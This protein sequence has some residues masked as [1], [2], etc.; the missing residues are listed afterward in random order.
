MIWIFIP[1]RNSGKNHYKDYVTIPVK[2]IKEMLPKFLKEKLNTE[3]ENIK[4]ISDYCIL[5]KTSSEMIAYLSSSPFFDAYGNLLSGFKL[6]REEMLCGKNAILY[7]DPQGVRLVAGDYSATIF[8]G[9]IKNYLDKFDL[10]G[11]KT[12]GILC[13]AGRLFPSIN[14]FAL[15]NETEVLLEFKTNQ[16]MRLANMDEYCLVF[17]K[18]DRLAFSISAFHTKTSRPKITVKS[19]G[20]MHSVKIFGEKVALTI[21]AYSPKSL[22]DTV[23]DSSRNFRNDVYAEYAYLGGKRDRQW[24]CIRPDCS[25]LSPLYHREIKSGKTYFRVL[26]ECKE[27]SVFLGTLHYLWCAFTNCWES[28]EL[29]RYFLRQDERMNGYLVVDTTDFFQKIFRK[30][31]NS[32]PGFVLAAKSNEPLALATGDNY[33]WPVITELRLEPNS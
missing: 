22:F 32:S 17:D 33:L 20:Y 23:L 19:D 12:D 3:L 30:K 2:E 9:N 21:N 18:D 15:A 5:E 10:M 14:G 27:N 31:K 29:P 25:V 24:L 16:E 26:N 13:E 28:R 1:D 8:L 6:D 7:R 4:K 11:E